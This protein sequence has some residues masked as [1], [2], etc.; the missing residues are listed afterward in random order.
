MPKMVCP[1]QV[2]TLDVL[3]STEELAKALQRL[4]RAMK[5][6]AVCTEGIACPIMA[7]F[8]QK[9][10]TALQQVTEEWQLT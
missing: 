10:Q 9:F 8:N 1:V 6:C 5:V 3:A 7:N 2:F 4:R